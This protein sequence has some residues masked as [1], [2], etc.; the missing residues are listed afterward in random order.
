MPHIPNAV[1]VNASIVTGIF[2]PTPPISLMFFFPVTTIIAPAQRNNVIFMNPWKGMWIIAPLIPF[3]VS[4]A[5]PRIIYDSWFIVEY[6]SLLFKLSCAMANK[7]A[8][9]IVKPAMHASA[10]PSPSEVIKSTP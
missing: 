2:F 3:E 10:N 4:N 1:M 7:L 5:A 8:T 9:I 6:A